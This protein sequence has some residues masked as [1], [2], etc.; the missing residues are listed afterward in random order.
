MDFKRQQTWSTCMI[1]GWSSIWRRCGARVQRPVK[2]ILPRLAPPKAQSIIKIAGYYKRIRLINHVSFNLKDR[3]TVSRWMI[4]GKTSCTGSGGFTGAPPYFF[5]PQHDLVI[6]YA[7]TCVK[8]TCANKIETMYES[9]AC[10]R[11]SWTTLNFSF[12]FS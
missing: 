4:I 6:F 1:R 12:N 7:P 11:K 2:Y 10:E 5:R 8:F 9:L 3:S